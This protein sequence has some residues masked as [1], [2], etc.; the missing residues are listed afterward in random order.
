MPGLHHV[1][2]AAPAGGE[3]AARAF[4]GDL[5]GFPEVRKP[6]SLALRGGVWFQV[7]SQQLHVGV[8]EPFRAA[9]KAHPAF[10]VEDLDG[11]RTRLRGAGVETWD[12]EPYPGRRRFYA[13]DP[14]GNRLEF[15]SP[16]TG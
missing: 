3:G 13:H 5:L 8:E 1:L 15:L 7:G 12:D 4:F 9:T 11:V 16:A 10:E 2:I 14:F 6:D